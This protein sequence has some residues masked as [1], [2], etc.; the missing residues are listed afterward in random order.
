MIQCK[1]AYEKLNNFTP[2]V[3]DSD[4][5]GHLPKLI[6]VLDV[7]SLNS[8]VLIELLKIKAV[9]FKISQRFVLFFSNELITGVKS[10]G[11]IIVSMPYFAFIYM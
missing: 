3:A 8:L 4:Q 10:L 2:C 1:L 7:Y 11:K 9:S 6:I 5:P